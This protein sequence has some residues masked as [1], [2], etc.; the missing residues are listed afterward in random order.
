[1]NNSK[2]LLL[3]AF[4]I[5]MACQP[6][7]TKEGRD[8]RPF[9]TDT[10][11]LLQHWNNA[12]NQNDVEFLQ[13]SLAEN[14]HLFLHGQ[15]LPSEVL[16]QWLSENS[17]LLIN[18]QTDIIKT[19]KTSDVVYQAGT[20]THG[21]QGNDGPERSGTFTF[22]WERQQNNSMKIALIDI[23]ERHDNEVD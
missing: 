11:M 18:L 23:T 21:I 22:I 19:N 1:M 15:S 20:Y 12:W 3:L 8:F 9:S 7:S 16:H 14:A 2:A 5:L 6:E 17:A 4:S 10:D 13:A